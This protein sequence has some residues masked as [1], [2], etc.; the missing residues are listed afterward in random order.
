VLQPEDLFAVT[1]S[2]DV[3]ETV[4][5]PRP[6]AGAYLE[7]TWRRLS[8]VFATYFF[9]HFPANHSI[10]YF[11]CCRAMSSPGTLPSV[12]EEEE[13]ITR[14]PFPSLSPPRPSPVLSVDLPRTASLHTPLVLTY[15]LH[16]PS[17]T[18]PLH[19]S[20]QAEAGVATSSSDGGS[21]GDNWAFAGPRRIANLTILP[22]SERSFDLAIVPIGACGEVELPRLRAFQLPAVSAVNPHS[23]DDGESRRRS[24][25][26]EE[27]EE[28]SLAGGD[29]DDEERR[30]RRGAQHHPVGSSGR[31]AG[32]A[33]VREL[34][35]I[36]VGASSRL[37]NGPSLDED[38]T[39]QDEPAA[40][41]PLTI[42]VVP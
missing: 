25:E 11:F 12:K 9:L 41:R 29:Y 6:R 31:R 39:D 13:G 30:R 33:D 17:L 23:S 4:A 42:F 28:G 36:V 1:Y 32:G 15:T 21:G 26:D 2:V 24:G 22:R 20:L 8:Y 40:A 27:R 35:L 16:N 19:V 37:K 3:A 14:I 10:L 5:P 18:T 7:V 34:D 38:D